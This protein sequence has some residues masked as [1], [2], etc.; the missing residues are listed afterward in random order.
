MTAYIIRRLLYTIPIVFG[1]LLILFLIFNVVG[2]NPARAMLGKYATKKA[3]RELEHQLG[4][5]LPLIVNL[6]SAFAGSERAFVLATLDRLERL[7]TAPE[8]LV[9]EGEPVKALTVMDERPRAAVPALIGALLEPGAPE[10]RRAWASVALV[11][12]TGEDAIYRPSAYAPVREGLLTRW[13]DWWEARKTRPAFA[14]SWRYVLQSQLFHFL[15]DAATFDFGKSIQRR[16]FISQMILRGAVPSLTVTIPGFFLAV[17]LGLGLALVCAF[18]RAGV[19]DRTIVFLTVIAMSI[20][21]LA[22]VIGG[23]YVLAH[24]L[25]LFPVHG[26]LPPYAKFVALPVLIFVLA[27]LA[28]D[29]RSFRTYI[30]DEVSQDYVRTARAKGV[31]N[32]DVMLRHVLK[33][34]MIPVI[35]STVIHLPFLFLGSLLLE[36]FFGI[37]GLG[38]T[39]VDAVFSADWPVVRAFTYIGAILYVVGNLA[40][41]ICYAFADPRISLR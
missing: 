28:P 5:D 12:I 3:V 7:G 4:L 2:G 31:A 8:K 1:V 13:R 14:P 34:A 26:Y 24:K 21:F 29:I 39:M 15:W 16:Q 33:N 22:Y 40:T 38:S 11:W 25:G 23:Q 19:V 32:Q 9:L 6:D 20:T 30:L 41:D 27:S 35:T 36:R 10:P 18:Y 17:G 37:P